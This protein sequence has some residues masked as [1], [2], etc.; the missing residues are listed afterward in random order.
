MNRRYV[1]EMLLNLV[2]ECIRSDW[3]AMQEARRRHRPLEARIHRFQ[4]TELL[5]LRRTA[6]KTTCGY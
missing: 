2:E 1:G 4:L 5:T 6:I 3:R